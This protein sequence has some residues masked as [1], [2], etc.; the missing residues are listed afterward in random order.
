MLDK[1]KRVLKTHIFCKIFR[2]LYR[3]FVSLIIIHKMYIMFRHRCFPMF[4]TSFFLTALLQ[5]TSGRLFLIIMSSCG[6]TR[7]AAGF[8][9]QR[10]R[11][12]EIFKCQLVYVSKIFY[13][14][15]KGSFSENIQASLC[16]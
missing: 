9:S 7:K 13:R 11:N 8:K 1:A 12:K 4:Q 2:C 15:F 6:I 3:S 14:C 5:N 16:H 10:L